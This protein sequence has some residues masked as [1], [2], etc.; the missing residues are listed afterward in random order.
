MRAQQVL[1]Q[2]ELAIIRIRRIQVA[3]LSFVQ[4]DATLRTKFS[5]PA[6]LRADRIEYRLHI[7]GM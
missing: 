7:G 1:V 2:K 6:A 5:L 3:I 4:I